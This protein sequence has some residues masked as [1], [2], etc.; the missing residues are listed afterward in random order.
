MFN[1]KAKLIKELQKDVK[2]FQSN[3]STTIRRAEKAEK[4][5]APWQEKFKKIDQDNIKLKKLVREQSEADLLI[6]ALKVCGIIKDESPKQPNRFSEHER[7]MA[8]RQGAMQ[9]LSLGGDNG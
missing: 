5:L 2:Y 3:Y 8:R 7:L 9:G 6:N 1:K 4:E